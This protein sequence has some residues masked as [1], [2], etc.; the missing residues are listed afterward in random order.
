MSLVAVAFAVYESEYG[1]PLKHTNEYAK[2][3]Y[4]VP[5]AIHSEHLVKH[6]NVPSTGYIHPTRIDVPPNFIPV[7]F[8]FR[9]ASSD[10]HVEQKHEG[11]PGSYRET[12]SADEPHTLV[13]KVFKPIVQE[14]H[15]IIVPFRK[16]TQKIEPVKEQVKTVVARGLTKGNQHTSLDDL[17]GQTLGQVLRH[18]S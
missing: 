9:T 6:L 11:S 17:K 12:H 15:E 14:V 3:E 8:V 1:V 10:L 13:H 2:G 7:H 5:A 16:V 18:K 4:I